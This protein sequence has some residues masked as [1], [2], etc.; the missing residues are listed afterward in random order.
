MTTRKPLFPPLTRRGSIAKTLLAV[1]AGT[2]LATGAFAQNARDI[3]GDRAKVYG[4][5]H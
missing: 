2:L 3:R 5:G 4:H 1:A